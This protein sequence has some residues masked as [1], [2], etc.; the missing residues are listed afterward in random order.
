MLKC[1]LCMLLEKAFDDT[2]F[3]NLGIVEDHDEQRLGEA[4]VAL[5]EEGQQRL[6]RPRSARFQEKRWVWRWKAPNSVALCCSAG[7]GTLTSVPLRNHPRW[8]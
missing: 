6:G 8:T 4:L 3:V 7:V 2:A 1:H 5:V